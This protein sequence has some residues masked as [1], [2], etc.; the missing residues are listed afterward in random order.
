M[1]A[2]IEL[3]ATQ[4]WRGI[5]EKVKEEIEQLT[6]AGKSAIAGTSMSPHGTSSP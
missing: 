1:L 2:I 5:F 6:V 4:L 3:G